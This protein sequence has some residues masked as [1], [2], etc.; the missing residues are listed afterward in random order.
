M[1]HSVKE[2]R[3]LPTA[4]LERL[5]DSAAKNTVVGTRH[6]LDE[7]ARRDQ[8]RANKILIGLTGA[9]VLLTIALVY[10]TFVLARHEGF[11]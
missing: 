1:S 2:L 10:L 11:I 8:E 9:I 6:Y 4:E 3:S 7:I 5:H